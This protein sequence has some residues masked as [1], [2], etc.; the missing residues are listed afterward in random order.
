[1]KNSQSNSNSRFTSR[2]DYLAKRNWVRQY[3]DFDIN[4]YRILPGEERA[5]KIFHDAA[6]HVPAYKDF[7]KKHGIDHKKVKNFSDIPITDK[8]NYIQAYP[9]KDRV[10]QSGG[11]IA[12]SSGTSG[13]PTFWPRGGYQEFEQ[14]VTHEMLYRK[15]F[16]IQ[17]YKTLMLVCFPMGM[18]ISGVATLIPSW[19]VGQKYPNLTLVSVGN[20][21]ADILKA[22]AHLKNDYEQIALVGHPFIIKDVLERVK[23]KHQ[24]VRIMCCS[25]GFSEDWR[26]YVEKLADAKVFNTYGSSELLLMGYELP[27]KAGY[28]YNP[29]IRYVESVSGELIFTAASG[30]PLVRFNL[31]DAG[32]V[33]GNTITLK[34][35]S[36]HTIIMYAANIYPEH[37][38]VG[39]NRKSWYSKFT[40]KF[41]MEKKYTRSR[42]EQLAINIELRSGIKSNRILTARIQESVTEN[43]KRINHEYL[44]TFNRFGKKVIP[45]IKLLPYQE[46]KYFPQGLKPRY[47]LT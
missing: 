29:F 19:L 10:W 43:L 22:L 33:K 44:D 31:H 36:D 8:K 4:T 28:S 3:L 42:D 17:K 7:I 24:R 47:I 23:L 38:R 11:I 12:M 6:T 16:E 45:V 30:V 34:G 26:N 41:S 40:G 39:L 21:Q 35:R 46:P 2:F 9:L 14:A 13:E 25:E 32:T 1:M 18:Y 20:R 15:Y 5:W 27:G 37:V